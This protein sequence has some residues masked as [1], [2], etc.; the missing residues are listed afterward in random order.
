[1]QREFGK[2]LRE[3]M[4]IADGINEAFDAAE[5]WLLA[6]DPAKRD[7][8]QTVCS[9]ALQGFQLLTVMLA[10][11]LPRTASRVA[12]ELFGLERDFVWAD[13]WAEPASIRPYRHLMARIEAKQVDAL[14]EGPKPASVTP[15]ASAPEAGGAA[16]ASAA[17]AASI[18]L[19]DFTKTDLRIARI[20]NAE[21][22]VGADKLLRLTL[23]IGDARHRTVFAGIK[24]AYRPG[25]DG[26]LTAMVATS[27]RARREIRVSEGMVPRGPRRGPARCLCPDSGAQSFRHPVIRYGL[28]LHHCRH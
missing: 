17:D 6:K 4:R 27:H 16:S 5:P 21:Q 23:D 22:V 15:A 20:V 19:D 24:S 28:P 3:A 25:T 9:K 14:L 12:R 13:A 1:M 2:I 26:R 8:L 18:A 11:V 7:L 10:P